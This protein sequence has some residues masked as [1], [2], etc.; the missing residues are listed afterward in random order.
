MCMKSEK[1]ITTID[2]T[3]AIILI[4]L[5][6]AII[7][8]LM[9]QINANSASTKRNSEATSYAIAEIEKLK[10]QDFDTLVDTDEAT[11]QFE[12]ITDET[13]NQATGY[14]KRI[15]ITD[16]ANLPENIDDET[17]VSGLVKQVTVEIA[18]QDGDTMQTV[19]LSTV[20]TKND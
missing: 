5:F 7:A 14:S 17:I 11:N 2:I 20:I 4:T 13:T 19:D 6:V 15:T 8:T 10:A 12:N 3:V 1:G 9:Y 18:Y 16:Y